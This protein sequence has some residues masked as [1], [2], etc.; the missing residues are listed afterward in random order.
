MMTRGFEMGIFGKGTFNSDRIKKFQDK[1]TK[2]SDAEKLEFMNKKIEQISKD[3]FSVEAID[4]R[5]EQWLRLT[6]AEK[7]DLIKE[8]KEAMEHHAEAHHLKGRFRGGFGI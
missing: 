5:R 2:M 4:E 3:P 7:E 8:R 1:W 6:P